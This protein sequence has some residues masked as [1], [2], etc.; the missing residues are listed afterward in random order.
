MHTIFAWFIFQSALACAFAVLLYRG[1][2]VDFSEVFLLAQICVH[3]ISSVCAFVLHRRMRTLA[4]G[5]FAQCLGAVL[6]WTLA[7]AVISSAPAAGVT[8]AFFSPEIY[9]SSPPLAWTGIAVVS[10]ICATLITTARIWAACALSG[11]GESG[12]SGEPAL[13]GAAD[14]YGDRNSGRGLWI[15]EG[16]AYVQIPIE[17]ILVLAAHKHSTVLHTTAG[18]YRA[19]EGLSRLLERLSPPDD[20]G[21]RERFVRVHRSFALNADEVVRF[22]A[23]DGGQYRATLGDAHETEVPVGRSFAPGL[24]RI[25]GLQELR[26]PS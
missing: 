20:V 10:A 9:G 12:E 21:S 19:P 7:A 16:Q 23:L 5:T 6:P 18:D 25:L 24:R 17:S 22:E 3:L 4:A 11:S 2:G 13:R 1:G 14:T 8:V 26:V 15:R